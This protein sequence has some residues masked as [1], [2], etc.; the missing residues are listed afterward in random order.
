MQELLKSCANVKL[1]SETDRTGAGQNYFS[2]NRSLQNYSLTKTDLR[3]I[4]IDVQIFQRRSQSQLKYNL[5]STPF[6]LMQINSK[7]LSLPVFLS[8][9]D[10]PYERLQIPG[11]AF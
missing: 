10:H 5:V 9:E 3:P 7:K 2:S 4:L 8:F 11:G 1:D 6:E